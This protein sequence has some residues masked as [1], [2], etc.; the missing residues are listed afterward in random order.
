MS[1]GRRTVLRRGLLLMGGAAGA[2]IAGRKVLSKPEDAAGAKPAETLQLWGRHWSVTST[3][4]LPGELPGQGDRMLTQGVLLDGPDG[5][6]VGEFYGTLF[7]LSAPGHDGPK[8]VASLEQHTFNLADG[9]IMGTGTATRDLANPDEFAI[10]GG[11]GRFAGASGTYIARQ[12]HWEFGGNGTA[13]F[14]LTILG[15]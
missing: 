14:T 11:L 13:Q 2:G 8:G 10:V 1:E 6:E 7:G 5:E 4:L 12:S 15:R 3:R 9:S